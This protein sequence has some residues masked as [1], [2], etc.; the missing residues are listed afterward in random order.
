MSGKLTSEEALRDDSTIEAHNVSKKVWIDVPNEDL[1]LRGYIHTPADMTKSESDDG[2]C[3]IVG[4]PHPKLG[5][6][7]TNNVTNHM[8]NALAN[9]YFYH[10]RDGRSFNLLDDIVDD[11]DPMHQES[12][13]RV[14]VPPASYTPVVEAGD[15]ARQ[16][17]RRRVT[18]LTFSTRGVGKSAGNSSWFGT[19]EAKD[20][21][22]AVQY[23]MDTNGPIKA[24]KIY[25]VG[26][27][28]SAAVL[29]TALKTLAED[30]KVTDV[31]R[32]VVLL[33]YPCGFVTR[34][35]LGHH[36][37]PL[38]AACARLSQNSDSNT[39]T[40][41]MMVVGEDDEMTSESTASELFDSLQLSDNQK[42]LAVVPKG[43]HFWYGQEH[44]PV[45]LV[46]AF[47][48]ETEARLSKSK[49]TSATGKKNVEYRENRCRTWFKD[50]NAGVWLFIVFLLVLR[51][52]GRAEH[53]A[54]TAASSAAA[55]A[56]AG[57]TEL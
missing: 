3:V 14:H 6:D 21:I 54:V 50:M 30:A 53:V 56:T 19:A 24:K 33:S 44:I 57:H 11:Y 22:A 55:A 1:K 12:V 13:A 5:G 43:T 10:H 7:T 40:G 32:G 15:I 31:L 45:R 39:G 36:C 4:H 8:V 2:I 38:R 35:L 16:A 18:T 28:F 29:G 34:F 51:I 37:E 46:D 48:E 49:K 25:V 27:S 17:L 23:C 41:V 47:I 52:A 42:K 26:Y 9:G 20:F